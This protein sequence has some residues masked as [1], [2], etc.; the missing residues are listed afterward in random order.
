MPSAD[1][2]D[3]IIDRA[4]KHKVVDVT[5]ILVVDDEVR[6]HALLTRALELQ[7]HR[8]L[9][10][11]D[12]AHTLEILRATSVDLVLLDLVLGAENGFDVLRQVQREFPALPVIVVSGVTDVG[13]R[14]KT[15]EAG[16]IDVVAK[17]FNL[18][19]LGARIRR[20]I[21]EPASAS[22]RFV[23]AGGLRLDLSRRVVTGPGGTR[24]L[25]ERE[26]A[27]LAYLMRRAGDVCGREELLKAVWEL[28][29]DP[30][31]NLVDV[32]IRRLRLKVPGLPVET[33]RGV[34]YCFVGV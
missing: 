27:L 5:S 25:A 15:L 11:L 23:Q 3:A 18:I 6:I 9:T 22:E 16:A 29:F 10:A 32:S 13:I 2:N 33:V 17:P 4:G 30:G 12:E 21:G 28:D 7:G 34:G 14:V 19:E 8:V 24:P 1:I 26:V 31:S 20:H